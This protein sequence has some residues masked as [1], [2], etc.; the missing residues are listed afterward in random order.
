MKRR[1]DSTEAT[2]SLRALE[3]ACRGDTNVMP[4]LLDAVKAYC[5][6]GEITDVM[7]DVFGIYQEPLVV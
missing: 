5:S 7:R 4:A 2:R 3:Q 6:L 1:R